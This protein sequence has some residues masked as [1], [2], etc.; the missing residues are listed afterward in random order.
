MLE[1]FSDFQC[2]R[3][4]VASATVSGSQMQTCGPK[5]TALAKEAAIPKD[6]ECALLP[7]AIAFWRMQHC[8]DYNKRNMRIG[9]VIE[10]KAY[11]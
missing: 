3:D 2:E 6:R 10:G 11:F 1:V 8:D 5:A 7:G 4:F 9:N